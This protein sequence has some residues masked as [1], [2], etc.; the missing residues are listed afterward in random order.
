MAEG[1]SFGNIQQ[2]DAG[3]LSVGYADLGPSEGPAVLLLHGW[4]YDIPR[5]PR[6]RRS[7]RPPVSGDRPVSPRLRR[8]ALPVGRRTA[9][10]H[11]RRRSPTTPSRCSMHSVSN[12]RSS[13]AS[14]G[15]RGQP[16]SSRLCGP[17]VALASYQ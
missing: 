16:T 10:Q 12:A 9:E 5:M 8:D 2:V 6:S 14:I 1:G 11:S 3:V 7:W 15:E 17:S 4:P 13:A